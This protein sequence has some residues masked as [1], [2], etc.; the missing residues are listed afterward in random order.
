MIA[1]PVC[2]CAIFS[3]PSLGIPVC[4]C[5]RLQVRRGEVWFIESRRVSGGWAGLSVSTGAD[6]IVRMWE[7]Y[8]DGYGDGSS[9]REL[10]GDLESFWKQVTSLALTN[11][12]LES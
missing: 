7:E 1:C 6:G 8:P 12:V 3:N 5:G 4:R 11:D 2:Q 10:H 9:T